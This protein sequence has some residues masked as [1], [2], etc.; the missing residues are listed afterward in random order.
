MG[1]HYIAVKH[2]NEWGEYEY[3]LHEAYPDI[4]EGDEPLPITES[5]VT[6]SGDSPEDLAKMLRLAADDVEKYAP[7]DEAD[8]DKHEQDNS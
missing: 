8:Y 1:W 6:V 7:V 5:S 4:A 3:N 2:K